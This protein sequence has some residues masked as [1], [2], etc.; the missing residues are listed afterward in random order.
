MTRIEEQQGALGNDAHARQ[1][2]QQIEQSCLQAVEV[3]VD[4][5]D[6]GQLEN[7]SADGQNF[8]ILVHDF[9]FLP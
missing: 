9:S 8:L 1:G 7:Q 5:A 4:T 6:L 2:V 3:G